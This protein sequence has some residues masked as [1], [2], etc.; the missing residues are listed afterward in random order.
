MENVL[1]NGKSGLEGRRS[2]DR[3]A[4]PLAPPPAHA[5]IHA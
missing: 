5:T 1:S 2:D 3:R 4:V